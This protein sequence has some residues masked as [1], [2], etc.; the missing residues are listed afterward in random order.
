MTDNTDRVLASIDEALEGYVSEDWAVSGDA[1]RWRPDAVPDAAEVHLPDISRTFEVAFNIAYEA[2]G[3]PAGWW[4]VQRPVP[5][6]PW[7]TSDWTVDWRDG[8]VYI[9]S[10]KPF[11]INGAEYRRRTRS[12]R[13]RNRR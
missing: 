13:R 4:I 3:R 6:L 1:M 10:P 7:P 9:E 8:A 11:A 2:V 12:R 5:E